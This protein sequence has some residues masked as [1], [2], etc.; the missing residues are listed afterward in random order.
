MTAEEALANAEHQLANRQLAAALQGFNTAERLGAEPNRCAGGRWL[1]H[2]LQGDY[3]AAWRESD[4]I[5][6]RTPDD[7]SRFW[8]GEDL[9]GKRVILRCLHGLGDAVQFLRFLPE[10]RRNAERITLEVPPRFVELAHRFEGVDEVITWGDGAPAVQPEWDV[11]V[12]INELLPMLR[13]RIDQL[14]FCERYLQLEAS[15]LYTCMVEP[16]SSEALRVGVVWA[17]GHWNL[18]RSVP[19][20]DLAAI[21]SVDHCEFWNLQGGADRGD[22]PQNNPAKFHDAS[23]CA[24]NMIAL[25]AMIARLDLVVS[26]DTLAVHLAGALGVSCWVMLQHAA[27]WRWLDQR[28]DSPWYP[29]LRLFRCERGE[30]WTDLTVRVAQELTLSASPLLHGCEATELSN[31]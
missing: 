2:M 23:E 22:W 31:K 21:M 10:L 9:T 13:L 15:D 14:P 3:N 19:F 28:S 7:P 6:S 8:K 25:A 5:Q 20:Q 24:D 12:E 17:S 16:S 30:T 18:S 29:S 1:I 26:S 27:D 4:A 11:Q